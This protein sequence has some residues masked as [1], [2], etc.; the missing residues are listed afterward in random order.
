VQTILATGERRKALTLA[1]AQRWASRGMIGAREVS[2]IYI[3]SATD[4]EVIT[5]YD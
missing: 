3:E 1:G 4:I 2:V 5:V